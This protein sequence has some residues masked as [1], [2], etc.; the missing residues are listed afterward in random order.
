MRITDTILGKRKIL[1]A[2]GH[3]DTCLLVRYLLKPFGYEVTTVNDLT[4][5][6]EIVRTTDYDLYLIA[7]KLSEGTGIEFCEKLRE[8]DRQTPILFWSARIYERDRQ[9]ALDAGA[10]VFLR[11]PCDYDAIPAAIFKLVDESQRSEVNRL[12]RTEL[13]ERRSAY[14]VSPSTHV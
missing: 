3:E 2:D 11:K 14:A 12:S 13:L 1:C 8:F 6:L 5:G 7:D 10:N 9:S 4:S